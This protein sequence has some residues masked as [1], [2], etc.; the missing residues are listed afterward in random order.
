M[1]VFEVLRDNVSSVNEE[2]IAKR[3]ETV[4][5]HYEFS[6]D[7]R[8][9]AKGRVDMELLENLV[10]RLWKENPERAV[11]LWNSKCPFVPE[12]KTVVPSFIYRLQ[13][14]E[15]SAQDS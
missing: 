9:I 10:Y 2:E 15:E 12:D 3:L 11:E 14:Q 7:F 13:V 4:D 1:K 8:R 5:W 6:D